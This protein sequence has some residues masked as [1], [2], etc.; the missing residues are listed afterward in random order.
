MRLLQEIVGQNEREAL[1][2]RK[3]KKVGHAMGS[4]P[5]GVHEDEGGNHW[6]VKHS[7]TDDHAHNEI[8]ANR[9][10]E[11]MGVPTLEPQL[12]R[13]AKGLGVASPMTHLEDFNPHDE[14]HRKE[15]AKHFAAHA[16]ISNWDATGP[17]NTNQ[18]HTHRGMTTVDAGGAL[19][20]RAMGSP[21]GG[22]FGHSVSEWDTLRNPSMNRTAAH[23]FNKM[24]P[25][26]TVD[27]SKAVANFR[28]AD[29]HKLVHE[30]GPG[31]F[32]AKTNLVDKM[33]ARK[34]DI[35]GRA[36]G[37]AKLNGIKPLKDIDG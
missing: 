33:I 18:A 6:Y 31:D 11:H 26:D 5:G 14:G 35:I 17:D 25:K 27:S 23:V 28:N 8:L 15:V 29:I 10:Y 34:R 20:Y 19:N 9:M 4:N 2:T 36:N 7:H 16:F 12:V 21:K 24:T 1:D 37:V 32:N 3:W 22:A 13:H 30:H